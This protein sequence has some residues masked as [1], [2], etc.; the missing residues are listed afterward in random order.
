MS[1]EAESQTNYILGIH[2]KSTNYM[3]KKELEFQKEKVEFHPSG[4]ICVKEFNG[5]SESIVSK[6]IVKS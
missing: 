2:Y 1:A 3:L 6:I 5:C 4:K